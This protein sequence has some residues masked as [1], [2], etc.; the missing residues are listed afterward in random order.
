MDKLTSNI[1][2]G[3]SYAELVSSQTD[4]HCTFCKMQ[5]LAFFQKMHSPIVNIQSENP[6]I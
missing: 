3:P 6:L 1:L 4:I 5:N 2:L